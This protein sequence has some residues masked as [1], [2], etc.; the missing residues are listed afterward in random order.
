MNWDQIQGRWKEFTGKARE[1]W[2]ELTDDELDKV[3]GRRDQ[4]A[5]LIQRKYGIVKEEAERQIRDF[6]DA[7]ASCATTKR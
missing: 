1:K 4:L 3:K 5:G 7:C 2:G 6:E